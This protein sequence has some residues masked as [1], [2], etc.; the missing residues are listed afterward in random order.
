MANNGPQGRRGGSALTAGK[1]KA[2]GTVEFASTSSDLEH[3]KLWLGQ[4]CE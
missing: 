2:R 1:P 3:I 4:G